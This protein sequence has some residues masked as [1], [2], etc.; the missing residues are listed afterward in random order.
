MANGQ[1]FH[2]LLLEEETELLKAQ[3]TTVERLKLMS[4]RVTG[5]IMSITLQAL[6]GYAIV[7]LTITSSVLQQNIRTG[8]VAFLSPIAS[9]IVS[10]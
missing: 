7:E 10:A 1:Q 5:I 2:V 4:R 6:A 3:R 9:S 8:S